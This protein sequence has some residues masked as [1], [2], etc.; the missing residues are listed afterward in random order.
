MKE[1][2]FDVGGLSDEALAAKIDEI[3]DIRRAAQKKQRDCVD[4]QNR[5]AVEADARSRL[6]RNVRLIVDDAGVGEA[7]TNG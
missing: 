7:P 3:E 2:T 6:G 5:R 1:L 4:E